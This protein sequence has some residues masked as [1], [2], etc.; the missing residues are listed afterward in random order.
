MPRAPSCS[1]IPKNSCR[2]WLSAGPS[3]ET[4]VPVPHEAPSQA[5]VPGGNVRAWLLWRVGEQHPEE[6]LGGGDGSAAGTDE[7]LSLSLKQPRASLLTLHT[8]R[9]IREPGFHRSGRRLSK[10][11]APVSPPERGPDPAGGLGGHGSHTRLL[12]L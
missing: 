9:A 8:A 7:P 2:G 4:L 12:W 5:A 10:A 6:E 3:P 11:P 1:L